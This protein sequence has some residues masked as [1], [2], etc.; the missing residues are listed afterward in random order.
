MLDFVRTASFCET[1]CKGVIHC[2]SW[3]PKDG[4]FVFVS[5]W[6]IAHL[7]GIFFWWCHM[8]CFTE[9][10][11]STGSSKLLRGKIYSM[12]EESSYSIL[13]IM[14]QSTFD[15]VKLAF[16]YIF[17]LLVVYQKE[18][19]TWGCDDMESIRGL[20]FAPEVSALVYLWMVWQLQDAC[21][22]LTV[23]GSDAPLTICVCFL[24]LLWLQCR[25]MS[26]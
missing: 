4:V 7:G 14:I 1:L 8:D 20:T 18:S 6:H 10:P 23:F 21:G 13:L 22:G 15:W 24:E 11:L 16:F 25:D 17:F 3:L 5:A 2:H 9:L 12:R 19:I 26:I